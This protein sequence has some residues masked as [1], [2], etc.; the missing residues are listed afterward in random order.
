MDVWTLDERRFSASWWFSSGT[1]TVSR[2][3]KTLVQGSLEMRMF[4]LILRTAGYGSLPQKV[5]HYFFL[6]GASPVKDH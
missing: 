6:T 4:V 3:E 1:A 2:S 5:F